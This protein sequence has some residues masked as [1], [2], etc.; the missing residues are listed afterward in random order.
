MLSGVFVDKF[1]LFCC[2]KIILVKRLKKVRRSSKSY[3]NENFHKSRPRE[4]NLSQCVMRL[5]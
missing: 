3:K 4:N 5:R 1:V 2:K